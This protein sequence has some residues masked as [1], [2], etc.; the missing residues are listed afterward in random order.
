MLRNYLTFNYILT[1]VN[2]KAIG[3]CFGIKKTRTWSG[4]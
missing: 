1:L 2:L 4:S 3:N